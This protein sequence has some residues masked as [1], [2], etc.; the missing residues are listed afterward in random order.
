MLWL[1][2]LSCISPY[3]QRT[4]SSCDSM[5]CICMKGPGV[6]PGSGTVPSLA[7]AFT[8]LFHHENKLSVLFSIQLPLYLCYFLQNS[9]SDHQLSISFSCLWRNATFSNNELFR[10]KQNHAFASSRSGRTIQII[11]LT[12]HTYII[13]CWECLEEMRHMVCDI[14]LRNRG[15]KNYKP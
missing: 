13:P 3:K 11:G 10:F 14:L 8:D 7:A 2:T 4:T 1:L 12:A 9:S 5:V 6:Y 15:S